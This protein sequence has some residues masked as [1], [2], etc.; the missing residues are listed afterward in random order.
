MGVLALFSFFYFILSFFLWIKRG[1]RL[2]RRGVFLPLFPHYLPHFPTFPHTKKPPQ[3]EVAT[4]GLPEFFSLLQISWIGNRRI[5]F[6][7]FLPETLVKEGR[8][9]RAVS[10]LYINCIGSS[11][12]ITQALWTLALLT[13]ISVKALNTPFY[14][15]NHVLRNVS[16]FRVSLV[17]T[18]PNIA[19]RG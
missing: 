8:Q 18:V 9:E 14:Y 6:F 17:P 3:V 7:C 13:F 15:P 5:G 10:S 11:N 16:P 2:D 12:T 19:Q 4:P 1:V